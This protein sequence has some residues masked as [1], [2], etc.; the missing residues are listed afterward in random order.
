MVGLYP[1]AVYNERYFWVMNNT[2]YK[3]VR[4]VYVDKDYLSEI[5]G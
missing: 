1:V 2:I 3:K 4:D 5:V